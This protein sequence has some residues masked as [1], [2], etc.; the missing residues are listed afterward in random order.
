MKK[1]F[2]YLSLLFVVA[3]V[4]TGCG[5]K[6]S[7]K[8]SKENN[9]STEDFKNVV[10]KTFDAKGLDVKADMNIGMKI[11]G[12]EVSIKMNMN[13]QAYY[14]DNPSAHYTIKSSTMGVE[15]T[16]EQ[17]MVI[18]DGQQYTYQ[19]VDNKGWEYTKSAIGQVNLKDNLKKVFD[20]AK[21]I[22]EVNSDKDGYTKYEITVD[23]NKLSDTISKLDNN[24][25]NAAKVS[26]VKF[27][28]YTKDGY[29]SIIEMD[30][31]DVVKNIMSSTGAENQL[32]SADMTGKVSI[33]L[34]NHGKVNEITVP[35]DVTS[36]AKE[37][38]NLDSILNIM[39]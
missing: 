12:M 24:K 6:D 7:K 21:E 13:G 2:K 39:K 23:G 29:V 26:D 34:S 11:S 15:S 36:S 32:A 35:Q 10:L 20:Q 28:A 4:L 25:S 17:Y 16:Q 30:L 18:K 14:G 5:K 33:E 31:T 27:T 22:K 8:E 38:N 1:G 19:K 3:L 37:S 9:N